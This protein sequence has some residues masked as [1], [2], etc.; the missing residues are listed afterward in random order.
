M[1]VDVNGVHGA[2]VGDEVGRADNAAVG[3]KLGGILL[4]P[5]SPASQKP[6]LSSRQF[7]CSHHVHSALWPEKKSES[8]TMKITHSPIVNAI[9]QHCR[10]ASPHRRIVRQGRIAIPAHP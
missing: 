5:V 9:W 2:L 7:N 3:E 4:G 1:G 6:S 10:R 8:R